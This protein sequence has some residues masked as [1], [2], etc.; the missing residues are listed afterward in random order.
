MASAAPPTE[1]GHPQPETAVSAATRFISCQWFAKAIPF[2]HYLFIHR[3][4]EDDGITN[5]TGASNEPAMRGKPM[6]IE[7]S[8]C[9]VRYRMRESMMQGFKG[10]EV[11]CRRCGGTIVVL[12]PE[13]VPGYPQPADRGE[14]TGSHRGPVPPKEKDG[15]PAGRE[16]SPPGQTRRGLPQA[17]AM[18]QPRTSL[19]EEEN[20]AEA[21]PDNVYS[22]DL[23]REARPKRLPTGGFDISGYIRPEPAAPLADPGPVPHAKTPPSAP[24]EKGLTPGSLLDRQVAWQKEG[25]LPL[26]SAGSSSSPPEKRHSRSSSSRRPRSGARYFHPSL[27]GIFDIA[28]VVL[29][30]F[31]AGGVGYLVV[32]FFVS[33]LVGGPR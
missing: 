32:R 6:V 24:A 27:P 3:K 9:Q 10:A 7:C 21:V 23:F 15:T 16:D 30:L 18:T 33:L 12:A 31:L 14:R 28:L 13:T 5:R 25:I 17:E 19:A 26:H 29:W 8:I 1:S 22:L 2:S 4:R 20:P 11:R